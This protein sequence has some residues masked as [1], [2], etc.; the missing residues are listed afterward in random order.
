MPDEVHVWQVSLDDGV[1]L[2][3]S[4]KKTLSIDEL[5][6]A[7]RFR[8]RQDCERFIVARG[9][10]R[11]LIA[12][13]L[14]LEPAQLRFTYNR[15][16]KPALTNADAREH[17]PATLRFNLSHSHGLALYAFTQGREVGVDVERIEGEKATQLIA[18]HFFSTAEV[19]ALRTLPAHLRQTAFFNCWTSK[20]AYV[21]ARGGGLSCDL[22]D[23]DVALVPGEPAALLCTRDIHHEAARWSLHRLA[24]APR[25]VATLAIENFDGRSTYR[26]FKYDAF[27]DDKSKRVNL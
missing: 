22:R 17:H 19:A 15:F 16:G 18:E 1:S 24:P 8:F 11:I 26:Q 5:A 9:V 4:L 10:L 13:Y 25:Y 21:K 6:R 27:A 7:G 14:K 23:F 3:A 20:E 12:R 2:L